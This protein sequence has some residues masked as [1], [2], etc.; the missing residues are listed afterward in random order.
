MEGAGGERWR[1]D[2]LKELKRDQKTDEKEQRNSGSTMSQLSTQVRFSPVP[3]HELIKYAITS[4][5][6]RHLK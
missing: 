4:V 3:E 6:E 5:S 2:D 1:Q